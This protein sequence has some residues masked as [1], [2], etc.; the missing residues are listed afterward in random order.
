MEELPLGVRTIGGWRRL[1]PGEVC[2][3]F[4]GRGVAGVGGGPSADLAEVGP[5]R[6]KAVP[7]G[8]EVEGCFL[9]PPKEQFC[10]SRINCCLN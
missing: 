5:T 9:L 2:I 7:R 3:G 6:R 10:L 1:G 4:E 8:E